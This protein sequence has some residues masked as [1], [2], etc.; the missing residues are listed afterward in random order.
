VEKDGGEGP[1]GANLRAGGD[2]GGS[3]S[4]VTPPRFAG[5]G[6]GRCAANAVRGGGGGE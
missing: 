4:K 3:R 5:E 1:G 6:R 2:P